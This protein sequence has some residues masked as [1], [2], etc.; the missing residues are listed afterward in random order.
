WNDIFI[1][2]IQSICYAK[3]RVQQ[4]RVVSCSFYNYEAWGFLCY[5]KL[6]KDLYAKYSGV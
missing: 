6:G 5:F 1:S 4:V 3:F 2:V